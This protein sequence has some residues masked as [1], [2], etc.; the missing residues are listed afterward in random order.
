[1]ADARAA[2]RSHRPADPLPDVQGLYEHPLVKPFAKIMGVIPISSEQRPREM[3][4]SLRAATRR[5]EERRS[6]LHLSRRTDDAHRPDAALPPRHGTHHEGRRRADHSGES[7]RRVGQRSSVL[8]A[9]ASSGSCRAR[10]RIRCGDFRQAAAVDGDVAGSA[11]G[12]AGAG[13]GS[14]CATAR[15]RMQHAAAIVYP[16]G[17]AASVPLCDGRRADAEAELFFGAGEDALPGAALAKAL[18]GPGDGGHPA[19]A[20]GSR[21]A[22]EFRGDADGQ[23]AGQSELHGFERNAGLLRAAV[24]I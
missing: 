9:G 7:G 5:A 6:G 12:R 2:D 24:R 1:M 13:R 4:H 10:F 16:H 22:G 18:A 19:A 15:S 20:V 23:G 14:V 21:R 3:I 17:A 11:P 8:R